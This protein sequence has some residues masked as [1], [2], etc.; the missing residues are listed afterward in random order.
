MPAT[1]ARIAFIT[2]E[3]RLATAGPDSSVV[4]RHGTAARDTPEPVESFFVNVADAETMAIERLALLS[5]DRRR[6]TLGIAGIRAL[7][8]QL[9]AAP[10]PTVRVIDTERDLDRNSL[11][12]ELGLDFE[13][14]RTTVGAWG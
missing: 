4:S 3:F 10:A 13:R 8:S 7:P 14:D 12:V 2:Q 5:P 11:V 1:P 6:T 9:A